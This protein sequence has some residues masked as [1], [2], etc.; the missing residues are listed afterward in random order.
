MQR[1]HVQSLVRE[2]RSHVLQLLSPWA[3]TGESVGCNETICMMQGISDIAKKT[4][5]KS[6]WGLHTPGPFLKLKV[7]IAQ[8][9]SILCD[10]M[11]WSPL[12]CSVRRICQARILEWVAK[13]LLQGIFPTQGLK[14]GVLHC[15]Q[16]LYCLNYQFSSVQSL[17]CVW[18]FVTLWTEACQPS[19]SIT[20]S[21]SLLKLMAIEL[22]MPSNYLILCHPLLLLPSIFPSIRVFSNES[23]LCIRWPKDWH[24]HFSVSPSDE[25]S[26]LISF[27]MDYRGCCSTWE[28]QPVPSSSHLSPSGNSAPPSGRTLLSSYLTAPPDSS[29]LTLQ[30]V[31]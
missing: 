27:R 18:L 14:P 11:D 10:H 13:L 1:T 24:F 4:N 22:V 21:R 6:L 29:Y 17:S 19:P 28:A 3:T 30:T 25:C 20:I 16:I 15:R 23:V 2:L 5:K 26:G 7:C 8:L 12:D 9:C 31:L